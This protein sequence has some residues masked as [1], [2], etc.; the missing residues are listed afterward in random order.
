MIYSCLVDI[1]ELPH[2]VMSALA[3]F[4]VVRMVMVPS[5]RYIAVLFVLAALALKLFFVCLRIFVEY[6]L[7]V[8]IV[9]NYILTQRTC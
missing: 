5:D 4:I 8:F 6:L 2:S 9:Q 7:F 3:C 1:L